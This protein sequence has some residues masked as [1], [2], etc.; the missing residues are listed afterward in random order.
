MQTLDNFIGVFIFYSSNNLM[1]KMSVS[2]EILF[3]NKLYHSPLHRQASD[4]FI[5]EFIFYSSTNSKRT[6]VQKCQSLPRFCSPLNFIIHISTVK[7][8][9]Y[10]WTG[11]FRKKHKHLFIPCL[12]PVHH[13]LFC[14]F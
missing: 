12:F 6:V 9:R 10:I 14:R 13:I 3:A 7:R 1:T 11:C 2:A 4:N 8:A 5:G